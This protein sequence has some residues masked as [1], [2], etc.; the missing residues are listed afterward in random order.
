MANDYYPALQQDNVEVITTGIDRIYKNGV[1]TTDGVHHELDVIILCT[2]FKAAEDVAPFPVTGIDDRDLATEWREGAEAYL[3]TVVS[4]FPN[5]FLLVGPNTGLGHTSMV[6]MIESQVAYVMSCLKALE[7]AG[8]DYM[9]V[10]PDVQ[11]SF[12][13]RLQERMSHTIWESG[14]TS[15]YQTSDGKNTTL[16]P[17]F[18]V[19]F[20][21]RTR[22][23]RASDFVMRRAGEAQASKRPPSRHHSVSATASANTSS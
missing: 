11:S 10:R 7:R 18:T 22:R 15:W 20:R 8:A 13:Q 14:C 12:N 16:W 1:V 6:F 9:D 23:A 19:E 5:L 21:A 17:G 3:G 2:G 4:G